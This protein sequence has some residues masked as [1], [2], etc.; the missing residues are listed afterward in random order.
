MNINFQEN[1]F[2]IKTFRLRNR[3][4]SVKKKNIIEFLWP[5]IGL[6]IAEDCNSVKKIFQKSVPVILEIG[7]GFGESLIHFAKLYKDVQFLGIEVYIPGICFCLK[8][9]Y[10]NNLNNIKI[11]HLD[12]IF[13]LKNYA[14]NIS[15]SVINIFFPDPWPKNKHYKRRML[16]SN[17]IYLLLQKLIIQ[18][19]LHIVTDSASYAKNIIKILDYISGVECVTKDF[20]SYYLEKNNFFTRFKQKANIKKSKIYEIIYKKVF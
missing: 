16:Q 9:I 6:N 2:Q 5:L 14:T 11:I 7:F 12:A 18:G 3:K 10:K 17:I 13:F 19:I 20:Q 8:K 4:L 1:F 15:F